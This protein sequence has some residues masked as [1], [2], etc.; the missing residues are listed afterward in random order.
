[1]K[2]RLYF[3]LADENLFHPRFFL[4]CLAK[5]SKDYEV[6]GITVAKDSHKRGLLDFLKQQLSLWGFLGFLYIALMS[7]I[8]SILNKLNLVDNLSLKNIAWKNN[9]EYIESFNVNQENH[10]N[11]LK[12]LN[13]DII[14]SSCGHIFKKEL[15]KLPKIACINRHT[16][17]L[18]KY[19]GVLPVFWAMY[20]E[21]KK[22]GV[23][24]HYMVEKIDR[25]DILSQI[26]IPLK[27]E[28]SLFKN[29]RLGFDKSVD[30]IILAL[31]N[32]KKRKIVSRFYSNDKKYFSFPAI[33][34]IQD[35]RSK[36]Y[37]SFSYKDI[38]QI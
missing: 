25:G 32:L 23:S 1:M 31:E 28:N 33:K 10:L 17:L 34:N 37:K 36:G 5:L 11:H 22:F 14:I 15:L 18:P 35:F 27:K 26:E 4:S 2:I 19:G 3:I 21:E 13:I 16:A 7:S 30:V 12:K 29:Y 6:A 20:F 9:I 8:R 24:I 38:F